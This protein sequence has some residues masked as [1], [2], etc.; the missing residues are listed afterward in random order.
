MIGV[1]DSGLGGLTIYRTLSKK[2]PAYRYLYLGD[3]ARVPYGSRSNEIIYRY[4]QEAVDFM[5]KKGCVLIILACNTSSAVA[6]RRLQQ[7]YLPRHYPHRRI[8]GVLIPAAEEAI[9]KTRNK[10][11][12]VI[13]TE[14]T[15]GSHTF[16]SELLKL[17]P[18]IKVYEK[19]CPLLVP[20]IE[21]GELNWSGLND[22]L[23]KYLKPL[24]EKKIDTLILGCTHYALIKNQI[25]KIMGKDVTLISEDEIIDFKLKNYLKRHPEIE[26]KLQKGGKDL[27]LVT[28]KSQKFNKISRLFMGYAPHF[29]IV[30][31]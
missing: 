6:L 19:A 20:I 5:F 3:N 27:L 12:G 1:F 22:I 7:E 28:A 14:A 9:L 21:A 17:D 18:K 4:S 15:I 16:L 29:Q 11:I 8:L 31:L 26:R 2:L 25:K 10:R 23:K 24:K 30:S 13:G